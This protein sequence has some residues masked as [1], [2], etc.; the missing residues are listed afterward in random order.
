MH[1]KAA[2]ASAHAK[3]VARARVGVYRALLELWDV[4]DGQPGRATRQDIADSLVPNQRVGK[5]ILRRFSNDQ[6]ARLA[7]A[8]RAGWGSKAHGLACMDWTSPSDPSSYIHL[9]PQC[10]T[11]YDFLFSAT[12]S[13]FSG[14]RIVGDLHKGLTHVPNGLLDLLICTMVFE[15]IAH[16]FKAMLSLKRLLRPGGVLL[17]SVPRSYMFHAVPGDFWR[18]TWQGAVFL[19][20]SNGFSVCTVASDG[21]RAAAAS[22][23]GFFRLPYEYIMTK[24]STKRQSK[25]VDQASVFIVGCRDR[26]SGEGTSCCDALPPLNMTNVVD[27]GTLRSSSPLNPFVGREDVLPAPYVSAAYPLQKKKKKKTKKKK[28]S[29]TSLFG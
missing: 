22:T 20:E 14:T 2:E 6:M 11:K 9:F 28:Q 5:S 4:E 26:G 18:Y 10:M 19:L 8:L 21:E 7:V 16:P 15:H 13:S 29:L 17:F 24:P 27:R 23:L 12:T 25:L 1:A 3:E